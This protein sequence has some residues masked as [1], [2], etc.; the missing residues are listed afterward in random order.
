MKATIKT[1]YAAS[2]NVG[3]FRK[4]K[5]FYQSY[6]ALAVMPDGSIKS[7]ADLRFY[8][9]GKDGMSPVYACIWLGH[10]GVYNSG[11]GKAGG[12]GYHKASAAAEAAMQ[13]A[14]ITLDKSIGGRGDSA[15]DAA[16]KAIGEALGFAPNSIYIHKAHA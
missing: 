12:C 10:N 1:M 8:F 11:G 2:T 15:I 5:G 6:S 16:L 4:E 3:K 7:L 14:G 13:A 9:V